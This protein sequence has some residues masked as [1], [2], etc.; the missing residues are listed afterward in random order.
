MHIIP[1][2]LTRFSATSFDSEKLHLETVNRI[3]EAGRLAPSAKNR[4]EWRF[5][6]VREPDMIN[7][8]ADAAFRAEVI[9]SASA[10]IAT[11]T[12]NIDY[13]MPNG[14]LSYPV[15]MGVATAF[16]LVQAAHEGVGSCTITT[17]DEQEVKDL[18]SIPHAMRVVTMIALGY[19]KL[20]DQVRNRKSFTDVVAYEHW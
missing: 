4:Q 2:I 9:V 13:R 7:K 19:D 14:Q 3:V 11:C 15:D 12:T 6:V 20:A 18:L 8:L 16:M 5:V 1:A 17:Y 10:L